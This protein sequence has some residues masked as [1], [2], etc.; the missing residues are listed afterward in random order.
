MADLQERVGQ[1]AAGAQEQTQ[2]V[3]AVNQAADQINEAIAAVAGQAS[4]V[5]QTSLD[6]ASRANDGQEAVQTTLVGMEEIEASSAQAAATMKQLSQRT[7]QIN[8]LVADIQAIANQTNLLAL[9][10]AIEAARA[11]EAGRGFAVVADEVR[12]LAESSRDASQQIAN[13]AIA[14]EAD[15]TAATR[16]VAANQGQAQGGLQRA[17]AAAAN[18]SEILATTQATSEA[19][20]AIAAAVE[21]LRAESEAMRSQ[22]GQTAA[23]TT[24]NA[25]AAGEMAESVEQVGRHLQEV[26]GLTSTSAASAQ[27]VAASA[28]E[29]TASTESVAHAANGLME[30]ANELRKTVER[31]RV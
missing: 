2:S 22:L 24:Q 29:L 21:Q 17:K 30:T 12:K 10:A 31:F 18:L 3:D 6:A 26:S 9:N 8:S 1:I 19:A 5:R 20:R 11:G 16:S 25:A 15:A 23:I 7:V 4:K 27:E 13:L 28:E 14:M